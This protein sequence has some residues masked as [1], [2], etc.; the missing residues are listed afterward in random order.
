[1]YLNA[2]LLTVRETRLSSYLKITLFYTLLFIGFVAIA[3]DRNF[4]PNQVIDI[5]GGQKLKIL[6]CKGEGAARECEVIQ[7][8]SGKQVGNAFWL[9]EN[10]IHPQAQTAQTKAVKNSKP[11][12]VEGEKISIG[13]NTE[14]PKNRSVDTIQSVAAPV[15]TEAAIKQEDTVKAAVTNKYYLGD[16][17]KMDSGIALNSARK[18]DTATSKTRV[19]GA[20][21]T[22]INPTNLPVKSNSEAIT[23]QSKD[24]LDSTIRT[25]ETQAQKLSV[26]IDCSGCDM[27]YIKSEL[28]IVD[29]LLDKNAADV[30]VL[31]NQQTTGG[32]GSAMQMILYGQNKYNKDLD[33][34]LVAIPANST[35]F[36]QRGVMLKALK[37]GL[38]PFLLKTAY[39]QYVD[40]SI[41]VPNKKQQELKTVTKDPWNYWV[42]RVG[43]DGSV[44]SDQIYKTV[45][46]SGFFSANRTTEKIKVS[47]TGN[48]DYNNYRYSYTDNGNNVIYN[49]INSDYF[50]EHTLISSI[51]AHWGAGYQVGN[52][53]STFSNNK[54][55][56]YV[57]TGLEYSIFPYKDVNTRFLTLNY[58]IDVRANQYYD[59]TI[60]FK[61]HEVLFG[62]MIMANM[63]FNQKWG[64]F[65]ST[66]SYS[67]FLKDAS[68]NN[69]YAK[70]NFYIRLTGGLSFNLY[71][72][73]SRV[74]DQV[75][76][77]KGSA[78]E[79]DVLTRRR[80]LASEYNFYSGI[81]ISWRFGSKLNNFV[82][83][84]IG[85]F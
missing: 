50:F 21:N 80:Q 32:G 69:I 10:K 71:A 48:G 11:K 13:K 51:G 53:N 64:T 25:S 20:Y 65:S 22:I 16:L 84:R 19:D 26:F 23:N 85:Y 63:S 6:R 34:I 35:S 41:N 67:N 62:Q 70:V 17:K 37:R 46:G 61:T 52:S 79:Q 82:N 45:Q 5:G 58:G 44:S 3:Q 73:G 2:E 68:L 54:R 14:Q 74:R 18:E 75:Y 7:L 39:G 66:L 33:T 60:Y 49:I 57:K 40:V 78:S 28:G 81:G 72:S 83:P 31:V 76:L 55:K 36:E 4:K 42:F 38:V 47:F 43:V 12:K 8:V 30:H 29:F 56:I 77:V 9:L 27:N 15:A 1:L 24:S 59:S